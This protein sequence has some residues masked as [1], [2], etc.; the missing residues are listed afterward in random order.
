MLI[1]IQIF[2]RQDEVPAK[3]PDPANRVSR[4]TFALAA[5]PPEQELKSKTAHL[6]RD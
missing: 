1:Y 2:D 5:H 3:D 6:L 4:K